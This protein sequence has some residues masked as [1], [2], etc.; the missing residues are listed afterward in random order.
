MLG[1]G[2]PEGGAGDRVGG[3]EMRVGLRG[4]V[5]KVWVPRGVPVFQA[6]QMDWS[7][8]PLCGG[9]SRSA[10]G[11]AVVAVAEEHEG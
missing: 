8:L 4:Q 3:D 9:G 1:G 7:Y 11:T 6:V 10:D 2:R 5:R